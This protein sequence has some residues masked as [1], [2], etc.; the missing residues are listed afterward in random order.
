ML[1]FLLS[2]DIYEELLAGK[3]CLATRAYGTHLLANNRL[4]N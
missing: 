4:S 3:A 1:T 2:Y